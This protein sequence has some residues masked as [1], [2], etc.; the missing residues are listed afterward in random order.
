LVGK[1]VLKYASI[2]SKDEEL[3]AGKLI[4][5]LYKDYK[6]GIESIDS[7][8]SKLTKL[9]YSLDHP[10]WLLM[11]SRNCEYATDIDVFREPFEQEF[12]YIAELWASSAT[13]S[14]F[15]SKYSRAVSNGHDAKYC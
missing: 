9:D 10:D 15:E 11:L 5:N 7:L 1:I 14:E 12:S 3:A 4:A 6:S 2:D 13:H 8:D